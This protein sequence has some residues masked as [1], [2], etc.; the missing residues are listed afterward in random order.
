MSG[1]VYLAPGFERG[2][3][4]VARPAWANAN[5]LMRDYYDSEW[6]FPVRDER[7]LF[8]RL[9]LE[10]FQS[11]LAWSTILVKRPAFRRAF[12]N[13]DV[14]MLAEWGEH[15]IEQL[16]L[17]A[18]IVR[19]RRKIEATLNNAQACLELREHGGLAK[20]VWT[21]ASTQPLTVRSHPEAPSETDASRELARELK[22]YSFRHVGPV[23]IQALMDATGVAGIRD[24]VS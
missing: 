3:D 13:F 21:Y 17:D 9:S 5:E 6:G 20:L 24:G 16:L 18:S 12:A 22:R 4:G 1:P 15:D 14:E 7:G 23:T 11:G 10:A 2:S 19:N 8:E